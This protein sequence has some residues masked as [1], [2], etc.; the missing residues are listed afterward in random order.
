VGLKP[1]LGRISS[2]T[3]RFQTCPYYYAIVLRF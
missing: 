1:A 3:G 2:R